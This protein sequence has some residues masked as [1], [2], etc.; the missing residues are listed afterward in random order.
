MNPKQVTCRYFMHGVCRE[1][2]RCLFSHDFHSS[3]PSII[4]KFYQRG[5]CTYG[6]RCRYDHCRPTTASRSVT[7]DLSYSLPINRAPISNT[8]QSTSTNPETSAAACNSRLSEPR[9][10]E[11]KKLVLRDKALSSLKEE[12]SKPCPE[13]ENPE[14]ITESKPHSYLEAIR[15]GLDESANA[16]PYT[17]VQQLCPYAAAGECHYGD[18]CAYL[19]GDLCDVCR[20]QVLHP[21]DPEKRKAHEEMCMKAFEIEMEKAFAAQSSEDKVCS[22]CM[23]VVYD[24]ATAS[25]RRFGILSNCSHTYCLSCIRQWRCAKQFENKIIKS[26][27]ECRVVSEFVIPS[28]YWVEDQEEKNRLIEGFK[29]GVGRKPCRYF[30]QGR[31]TCPFGGKCFYLH[32]YPDGT[33]AEPE[34][35]RKQLSSE[36]TVRFLNSVRLWDF[37]EDREHRGVAHSEDDVTELGE[38]FMQLSQAD[39]ETAPPPE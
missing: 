11:K 29:Q 17:D 16:S 19:H 6:D 26:C 31:G 32:A 25:E 20:L 12:K 15:S 9:R 33:R 28:V 35:P 2:N 34:K 3:K 37:I 23:E 8:D 22:I 30:D 27:P 14:E 24:K 4:C 36:G 18:T 21:F 13:T 38:L 7:S 10:R 5:Q 39:E 1:G